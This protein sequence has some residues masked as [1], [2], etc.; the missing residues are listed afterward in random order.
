MQQTHN[1][2]GQAGEAAT[3]GL[4]VTTRRSKTKSL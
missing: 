3:S 4:Y 2:E 1:H